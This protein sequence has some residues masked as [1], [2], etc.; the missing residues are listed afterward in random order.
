M[1]PF[2][3]IYDDRCP[4]CNWYSGLFTRVGWLPADGRKP[5]SSI[6]DNEYPQLDISRGLQEIPLL[7]RSTGS[8][9]YGLDALLLIIEQQHPLLVKPA[10]FKPVYWF[11]KK[12]YK[13]VS[14][15]RKVIVAV[16]CGQNGFDCSPDFNI[17]YRSLFMFL[18][19]LLNTL[20]LFPLHHRVFS[21]LPWY[22][23]NLTGLQTAHF[24][25]VGVH[26]MIA[27][28]L[29]VKKGFEFL[30]QISILALITT[31][32]CVPLLLLTPWLKITWFFNVWFAMTGVVI[33]R[34]WLRRMEY[35][36]LIQEKRWLAAFHLVAVCGFI[37]Y[38]TGPL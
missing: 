22:Q 33:F 35:V 15:N 21:T 19:L 36:G 28:Y 20:L 7:D 2:L 4:L 26:L 1:K 29:G 13:L 8:F 38:M 14:F 27:S 9:Y 17:R 11:L 5:F 12:L 25:M 34:E 32:A 24:A 23:H 10:R 18:L 30:G 6:R 31:M 16:P 37:V 3:L